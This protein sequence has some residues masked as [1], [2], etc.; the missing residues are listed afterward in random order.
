MKIN[1][2]V[3]F[4]VSGLLDRCGNCSLRFARDIIEARGNPNVFKACFEH[5]IYCR[6]A[7]WGL[8][9]SAMPALRPRGGSHKSDQTPV[10]DATV[11]ASK[12]N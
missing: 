4:A 11:E 3:N 2:S 5:D 9:S 6:D 7:G 12:Y 10:F 8:N 1:D